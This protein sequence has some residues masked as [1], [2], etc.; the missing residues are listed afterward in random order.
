MLSFMLLCGTEALIFYY[1]KQ[2]FFT[3]LKYVTVEYLCLIVTQ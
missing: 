1:F 2:K 3:E